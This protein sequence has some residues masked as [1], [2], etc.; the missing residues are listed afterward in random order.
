MRVAKILQVPLENWV[1][2]L[3]NDGS[4]EAGNPIENEG[5]DGSHHINR[6][7]QRRTGTISR[8]LPIIRRAPK[9]NQ[10]QQLFTLRN[11][12]NRNPEADP[13]RHAQSQVPR[14]FRLW[15]AVPSLSSPSFSVFFS[16]CA[17]R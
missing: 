11:R 10:R 16:S 7:Q 17:S 9:G 14:E 12:E 8:R 3:V 13:L 2:R 4:R 15:R 5:S 6:G 1:K